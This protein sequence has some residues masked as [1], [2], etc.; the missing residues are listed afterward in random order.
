MPL[1]IKYG[2]VRVHMG[3]CAE[4]DRCWSNG[5]SVSVESASKLESLKFHL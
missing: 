1:W 5:K 3:Y 4:F 2:M